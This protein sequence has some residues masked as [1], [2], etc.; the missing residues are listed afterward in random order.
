MGKL[1][2]IPYGT[3]TS[4]RGFLAG[5]TQA[6]IK[7]SNTLDLGILYSEVPCVACGVFTTNHIKAAPV[8]LSQ[9]HLESKQA[10]AIV[11]NSGCANALTG[12]RGLRNAVEMAELVGKKLRILPQEVLV[13]STGRIGT[14]LP[15]ERVREGIKRIE[16]SKQGGH[17]LA[18]SM[19]TTDTS[20]KE[21][22]IKVEIAGKGV[23]IGGVAKGAGMIHPNL[24]TILCF[25]TTDA[26]IDADFLEL[27]LKEAVDVSFNM[28]TIDGDTSPN[29]SVFLLANRLAENPIIKGST[30][31]AFK[32][33]LQEV[34]LYLAK[35]I[36]RDGEGA[37][38][39]IEVT[40]EGA[41]SLEEARLAARAIVGS[42]LVK[43][44]IHGGDPNWGRIIAALGRSG[45]EV[46]EAKI[47]LYL[48][49]LPIMKAGS[50]LKFDEAEA[51]A[52]LSNKK[53]SIKICLNLGEGKAT[54]W[55]CDLSEEYIKINSAYMT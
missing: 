45:A 16:I 6:G 43:A 48:G 19:M 50:P 44:A 53:V 47:D 15:M 4:P 29:D 36:V 8:I 21:R 27:A 5:A 34:C 3:I 7:T 41:L 24:A 35:G 26:T 46:E 1:K 38:K 22:A 13:A 18:R 55:G 20:P 52:I 39:L 54:A 11:V 42:N 25:L 30:T 9:K 17:E 51:R 2:L 12:E 10:R 23:I 14:P 32:S 33:A 37:T 49:K 28:I 40:V 31:E